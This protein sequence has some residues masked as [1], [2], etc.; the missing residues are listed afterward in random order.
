M[1]GR[2]LPVTIGSH[3]HVSG[4]IVPELPGG[5]VGRDTRRN[6]S[7]LALGSAVA[8]LRPASCIQRSALADSQSE[9]DWGKLALI[10]PIVIMIS[11]NWLHLHLKAMFIQDIDRTIPEIFMN[12]SN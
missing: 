2:Y 12:T 7:R 3:D 5:R 10:L 1:S 4:T 6:T 8:A 9:S 11:S